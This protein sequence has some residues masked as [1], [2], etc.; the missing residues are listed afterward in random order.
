MYHLRDV[1]TSVS[2]TSALISLFLLGL[3]LSAYR[4]TRDAA[5]AFLT[6]AFTIF[7]LKSIFVAYAV[8]SGDVEHDVVELMDAVG[9]LATV[10]L[11]V[12]PIFWPKRT[13]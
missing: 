12:T 6:G 11:L 1:S 13:E 3:A 9:D 5:F 7:S 8:W 4:R 10:L 2:L